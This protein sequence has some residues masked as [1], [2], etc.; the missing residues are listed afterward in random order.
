[1]SMLLTFSL[2]DS[3]GMEGL[4]MASGTF[5]LR[6]SRLNA[7]EAESK[8]MSVDLEDS[9]REEDSGVWRV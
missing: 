6:A 5:S 1:M 8:E 4:E 7:P 3:E 9:K 2:I